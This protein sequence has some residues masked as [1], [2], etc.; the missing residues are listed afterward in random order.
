MPETTA[1]SATELQ[2]LVAHCIWANQRWIEHVDSACPSDVR[3]VT[4]V[5]HVLLGEQAWFDRLDG[6]E[7]DRSLWRPLPIDEQREMLRAHELTYR[8]LLVA[9]LST[10]LEYV[11]FSGDRYS[12]SI[13]DIVRHLVT[14]GAH[15]RGQ[16]AAHV[17]SN[18]VPV[19]NTD[20]LGYCMQ[21][22][23]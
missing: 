18:G 15:H 21:H 7:P 11:R 16:L 2:R 20:F 1:S 12:S 23:I 22:Q 14:H 9:D 6:K 4:L 5:S 19:I 3:A 10:R 17:S 13:G 8:R